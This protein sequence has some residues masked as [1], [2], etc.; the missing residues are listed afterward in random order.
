MRT[1]IDLPE[2]LLRRAKA[3]AALRGVKLKELVARL[4]ED[5]LRN[6]SLNSQ[7]GVQMGQRRPIPVSVSLG[8]TIPSLSN[9]EIDTIFLADDLEKLR[10]DRPS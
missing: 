9:Q 8:G 3:A 5:G 1:T 4:L 2:D 7:V 10:R 6:M